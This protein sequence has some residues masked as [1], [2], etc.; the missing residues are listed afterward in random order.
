MLARTLASQLSE[1]ADKSAV[2]LLGWVHRIRNLGGVRFLLLR[3]RGG[4]AQVI[5]LS[6]IDLSN[7]GSECVVRVSGEIR[8]EPRAPG[9]HEVLAREIELISPA[10]PPPIE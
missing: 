8:A 1:R 2:I 3:D 4:I 6:S 10:E 5:V 9:G 7:V